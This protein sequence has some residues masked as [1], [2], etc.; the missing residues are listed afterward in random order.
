[1]GLEPMWAHLGPVPIWAY[2]PSWAWDPHGPIGPVAAGNHWAHSQLGLGP[3]GPSWAWDPFGP[4]GAVGP[5]TPLG[6]LAQLGL[7]P[8]GPVRPCFTILKGQEFL[9]IVRILGNCQE[10]ST[11][12]NNS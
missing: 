3:V 4:F 7:G 5:G 12:A 8:I 11:I 6:P 9:T 2:W 10:F 1:M